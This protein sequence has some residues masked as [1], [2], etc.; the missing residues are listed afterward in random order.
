MPLEYRV[1]K[2]EC[3]SSI[4][5]KFG[6]FPETLWDESIN[7]EL[8]K[9]R[10]DPNVLKEGDIVIIPDK[11]I[12]S[13]SCATESKHRFRRKG[14]PEK[15]RIFFEDEYGKPQSIAEYELHL[16]GKS[17]LGETN[18]DGLLEEYIPL[19]LTEGF[20][21]IW[22]NGVAQEYAL[23]IGSLDPM[24]DPNGIQ[25]RLSNLGL[26]EGRIDGQIGSIT[27]EAICSFQERNDLKV[28]GELDEKTKEA[29]SSCHKS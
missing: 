24:L 27:K 9:L 25:Q 5:F 13:T 6:F 19:D 22:T 11:R 29:L 23:N 10:K 3:I 14:I 17:V 16:D 20:I 4:A 28:T 18:A 15:L 26:Y 21:R 8:I 7:H 1:K 2:K 12:K